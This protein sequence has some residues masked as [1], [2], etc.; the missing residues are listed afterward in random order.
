MTDLW[1]SISLFLAIL[2][3]IVIVPSVIFWPIVVAAHDIEKAIDRLCK[4]IKEAH[5]AD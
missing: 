3:V 2:I 5:H 4:A 1:R